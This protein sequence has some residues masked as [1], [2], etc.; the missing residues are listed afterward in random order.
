VILS[1][2]SRFRAGQSAPEPVRGCATARSGRTNQY[3]GWAGIVSS[4]GS[5]SMA[6]WA[7][8]ETVSCRVCCGRHVSLVLRHS[9]SA[10]GAV[11]GSEAVGTG[12]ANPFTL[13]GIRTQADALPCA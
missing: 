2:T 13:A 11:R 12:H 5:A 7:L 3:A 9:R 10:R 4:R 1:R 6:C 8:P